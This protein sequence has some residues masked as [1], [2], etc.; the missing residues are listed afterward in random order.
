Y[1]DI[2]PFKTFLHILRLLFVILNKWNYPIITLRN[3]F[4]HIVRCDVI[5]KYETIIHS[6]FAAITNIQPSA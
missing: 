6:P 3:Y 2:Y 1:M 5:L 4:P